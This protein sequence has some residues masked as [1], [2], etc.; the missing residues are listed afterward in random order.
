[1]VS[2]QPSGSGEAVPT[3]WP[4]TQ[5]GLVAL[6]LVMHTRPFCTKMSHWLWE[7]EGRLSTRRQPAL[8]PMVTMPSS[9]TS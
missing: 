1:M 8:R 4:L 2:T 9:G 5:V 7:T 6:R 3:G